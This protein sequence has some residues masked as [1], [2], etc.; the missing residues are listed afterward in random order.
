[1]YWAIASGIEGNLV[2]YEAMLKDIQQLRV[3]VDALYLLGDVVG[4]CRDTEKL[5]DRIMH[6]RHG[7]PR[8]V[9]CQGWWEEQC[10]ILHGLGRSGEP[11]QLFDRYGK[12]MAKT[13]WDCVPRPCV[14]WI[15]H[16]EFGFAELDC[17]LIHGSSIGVDDELTPETPVMTILD[18]LNRMG[19]NHFFCGRSG[20]AFEYE[21]QQGSLQ[22]TVMRL[23]QPIAA[24]STQITPKRLI[25]V[26]NVG[27]NRGEA[28]YVLYNPGNNELRFKTVKYTAAKGFGAA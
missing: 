8:P 26:G 17:L 15:R 27:R 5:I 22:T 7:E 3:D 25:G 23:D 24:Q 10:L 14:E 12:D 2:A 16:L 18:R 19:V 4:P 20:A 28:N 21:I 11:T 9:V 1:M 6:P 13:L